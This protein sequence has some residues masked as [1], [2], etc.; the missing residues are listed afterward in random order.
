[1]HTREMINCIVLGLE[2]VGFGSPST[3]TGQTNSN[4][5]GG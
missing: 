4:G 3:I 5:N 2:I 1:M